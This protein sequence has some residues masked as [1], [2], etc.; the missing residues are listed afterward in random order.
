MLGDVQSNL[1]DNF[2]Q[3]D[4]E[5]NGLHK[6][7]I[8]LGTNIQDLE[9]KIFTL[10]EQFP[11][12]TGVLINPDGEGEAYRAIANGILGANL[13]VRRRNLISVMLDRNA[14][15]ISFVNVEG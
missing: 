12:L 2:F 6:K 3:L 9:D 15:T 7:A 14:R 1:I 13:Q 10:Y 4:T 11:G 5:I 8:D